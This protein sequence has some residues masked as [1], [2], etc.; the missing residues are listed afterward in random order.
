MTYRTYN[1]YDKLPTVSLCFK[2]RKAVATLHVSPCWV[3]LLDYILIIEYLSL[4]MKVK[5]VSIQFHCK[6][7]AKLETYG[8][9]SNLFL[10]CNKPR[11]CSRALVFSLIRESLSK[12]AG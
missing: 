9:F 7:G 3:I 11:F 10:T 4:T 12:I 2:L 6:P 8:S 5:K 1:F